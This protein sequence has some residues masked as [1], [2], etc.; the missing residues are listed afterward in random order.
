[1]RKLNKDSYIVYKCRECNRGFVLFS[2]EVD[3]SEEES[4]FITCPY[5]GK[6]RDIIVINKFDSLKECMEHR[7]YVKVRGRIKQLRI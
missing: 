5:Y 1:M 4:L 6:H 7:A 2:N 3:H